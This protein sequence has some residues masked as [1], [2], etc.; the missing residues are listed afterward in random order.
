MKRTP[1]VRRTPL[2]GRSNLKRTA[3]APM[4]K[5]TKATQA[6]RRAV[7]AAVHERDRGCVARSLVPDVRCWGPMDA[8]EILPRGRGG[9][10]IDPANV[11]SLCRAHHDWK[12]LNP[13]RALELGLTRSA[14]A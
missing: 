12:H 7:V 4:S 10:P 14:H 13:R 2:A 1:L 8:D 3:L 11:Q 5:R 9:S 6:L